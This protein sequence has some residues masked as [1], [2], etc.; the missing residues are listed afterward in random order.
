[1][2]VRYENDI[3]ICKKNNTPIEQNAVDDELME[4][5]LD[6]VGEIF[7]GTI[8]EPEI[9]LQKRYGTEAN[10]CRSLETSA[11]VTERSRFFTLTISRKCGVFRASSK[12]LHTHIIFGR[13]FEK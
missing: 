3:C 6:V 1:M 8:C 7:L 10:L 13:F 2:F 12:N 4:G 9:F 11:S 5:I